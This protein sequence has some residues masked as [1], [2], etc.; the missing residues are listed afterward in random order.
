[1]ASSLHSLIDSVANV[2]AAYG[3]R[4]DAILLMGALW[5]ATTTLHRLV[6]AV[7]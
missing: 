1:M 6:T 2:G 3:W 7:A 5:V 4:P